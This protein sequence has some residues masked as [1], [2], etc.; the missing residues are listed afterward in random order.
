MKLEGIILEELK[1]YDS[2]LYIKADTK[3]LKAIEYIYGNKRVLLNKEREVRKTKAGG[4]AQSKYQEHVKWLKKQTLNW[5]EENLLKNGVLKGRYD[6]IKIEIQDEKIKEHV[7]NLL[8]KR[9]TGRKW[10]EKFRYEKLE[11]GL[12]VGGKDKESNEELLKKHL[13][14][15]DLVFHTEMKGSPFFILK[16]S[17]DEKNIFRAA[18][19]TAYY[20]QDWKKNNRDVDVMYCFGKNIYKRK[21]MGVGTFGVTGGR[22]S[23][24][25][26]RESLLGFRL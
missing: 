25:I 16:E 9:E 11:K 24:A 18:L 23:I 5:I 19:L 13:E 4:F 10:F 14:K 22:K 6:K 17:K 2:I 3:R 12:I 8:K 15:D 21:D 20:S 26:R 7:F 1:D